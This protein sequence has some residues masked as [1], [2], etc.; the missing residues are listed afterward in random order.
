MNGTQ[1]AFCPSCGHSVK[2]DRGGEIRSPEPARPAAART[3]NPWTMERARAIEM[4]FGKHKGKTLGEIADHKQDRNY[5]VWGSA[6]WDRGLGKA[7][8][9]VLEIC[10]E[11]GS[12]LDG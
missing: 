3:T 5:L 4:P 9:I 11:D 8:R 1:T 7:T 10:K 6:I 12:P 2:T